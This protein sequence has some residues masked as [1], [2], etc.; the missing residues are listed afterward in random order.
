MKPSLASG[1]RDFGKQELA[2]RNYIKNT[3]RSHFVKYAFSPLETPAFEKLETLMGKYGQEG[4]KLMFKILNNGLQNQS[5]AKKVKLRET[6]DTMLEKPYSSAVLTDR[7]LKYDLTIPLARYVAMNQ[8]ALE[9]P[10]RRYQMQAVW[11]ADRPQ[12]GRFREFWQCDADIVGAQSMDYDAELVL[13]YDDAFQELGIP[14]LEIAI[15][16]RK[17]LKGLSDKL[18]L[19]D[20]FV[21]FT[22]LLD[23]LDKIGWE[24]VS[25]KLELLGV[26]A[27]GIDF[28]SDFL[29][30]NQPNEEK[31]SRLSDFLGAGVGQEGIAEIRRIIALLQAAKTD[32]YAQLKFDLGL[33]RGLDYYTGTILEVK[34]AASSIG[35]IGGG[36]RYDNLT[37]LFDF[38]D[39]AGV[40]ISFGLDRIYELM[41]DLGLFPEEIVDGADLLVYIFPDVDA[42]QIFGQIHS[43]RQEG[44]RVDVV[45]DKKKVDKIYRRAEND[46]CPLVALVGESE[47]QNQE[48]EIKNIQKNEKRTFSFGQTQ[49]IIK[50]K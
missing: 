49:E 41:E 13:L 31:L 48:I 47:I 36:G 18:R 42:S 32:L 20:V 15:N 38:P 12:K 45:Y 7:V 34:S 25:E 19:E 3:I 44:L 30:D 43:W 21:E 37:E 24:K 8:N 2:K 35:S 29:H 9:F 46:Q 50:F 10:Y 22:I 17:I 1:T 4:D 23:K 33:A 27:Q 5:E 28:L 14:Q 39:M 16:N 26:S 6:F 40:G 11:R